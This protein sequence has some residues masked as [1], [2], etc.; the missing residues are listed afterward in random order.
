MGEGPVRD[1]VWGIRNPPR[2]GVQEEEFVRV[3]QK[4]Q[5]DGSEGADP[6]AQRRQGVCIVGENT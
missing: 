3:Q 5:H 4:L 6:R 2:V 1:A